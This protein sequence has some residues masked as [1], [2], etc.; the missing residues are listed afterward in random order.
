M[1]KEIIFDLIMTFNVFQNYFQQN[2]TFQNHYIL[3]LLIRENSTIL[4]IIRLTFWGQLVD[5]SAKDIKDK[6]ELFQ[7]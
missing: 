4:I 2:G 6:E 7:L 5:L 3:Q 1:Q